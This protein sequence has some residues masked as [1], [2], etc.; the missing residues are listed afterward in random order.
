MT[1]KAVVD[2]LD[3]IPENLRA[4]YVEK[5]GKYHIDLDES[6]RTHQ[7]VN[8]L[9]TALASVK[10]DKATLQTKINELQAKVAGLP[11]DFDPEQYQSVLTELE[12]L[13]T[14]PKRN[15]DTE[16]ALAQAREQYEQRLRNAEKKREED[17][18]AKDAEL[19][20]LTNEL[21]GTLVDDGLTKALVGS[22][23]AKEFLAASRSLLKPNV[24]VKKDDATG[25]RIAYV[26]TDLGEL[27]VEKYVENWSK[28]DE[29]KVFVTKPAG[30]GAGGNGKGVNTEENPW[31]KDTRNMTKQG[32]ILRADK[33]KA[34]RLM[35][36][37]GVPQHEIS[38]LVGA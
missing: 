13:K 38:R 33:A 2:S 19:T 10:K 24:K 11:D 18:A 16:T 23:V 35:K 6:L 22:G 31:A 25:K 36:A 32:E 5:D 28:S 8:P 9:A 15:K 1:L 37:A 21:Q 34:E 26:E 14:D 3:E 29:G 12:A 20:E 4:E 30:G 7:G 27:P 17:L